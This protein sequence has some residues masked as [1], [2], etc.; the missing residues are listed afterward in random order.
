MTTSI[1]KERETSGFTFTG[2]MF[3]AGTWQFQELPFSLCF[4]NGAKLTLNPGGSATFEGDA[5]EAA[6][7]FFDS[8]VKL[9]NRQYQ[10][11]SE[12]LEAKDKQI[13]ELDVC[14][15]NLSS[16]A[17]AKQARIAELEAL[18]NAPCSMGITYDNL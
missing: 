15:R 4:T 6:Q 5:D 12:T 7:M 14:N 2:E 10:A 16:D 13:A 11:L 1:T 17:I 8:V 18:T 9:H 3:T